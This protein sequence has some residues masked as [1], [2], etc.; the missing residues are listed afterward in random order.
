[1]MTKS[2]AAAVR[3]RPSRGLLVLLVLGLAGLFSS[4]LIYSGTVIGFLRF[5]VFRIDVAPAGFMGLFAETTL[6]V[7]TL[8]GV[9]LVAVSARRIRPIPF[10]ALGACAAVAYLCCALGFGFA[11]YFAV[12]VPAVYPLLGVA[13][14]VADGGLVLVW[15][16]VCARR[17]SMRLALVMVG[18]ASALSAGIDF[19]YGCLPLE[20]MLALLFVCSALAVV[21][22]L[23]VHEPQMAEGAFESESLSDAVSSAP[24]EGHPTLESRPALASLF[25][26]A[27]M[28]SLGLVAFAFVMAVMRTAFNEGQ[29]AYL[30]ALALS[31]A[32]IVVFALLK[33]GPF[34]LPGG[35]Q[36][37]FLPICALVVL[38]GGSITATLDAGAAVSDWLTYGL[39]S[40]AAVLTLATLCAV[41][42]AGEFSADLVFSVALC[43]FCGA[44]F[45][46]QQVGGA[47]PDE[48]ISVAVTVTTTLYAF[49]LVL[50][51]YV[52]RRSE[53]QGA[54]SEADGALP[55]EDRAVW[56]GGPADG[57][58]SEM[59]VALSPEV[60]GA[61]V[62]AEAA[63]L[64]Q[65]CAALAAAHGLTAREREILPYLAEGHNGSYIASVLF[66]SPNTARTHIHNIYRKL[67]VSSREDILRLTRSR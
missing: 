19:L 33:R 67:D 29:G 66:I 12:D 35:L 46:G 25:D 11:C 61:S 51:S 43:A 28:S 8:V 4:L 14:G 6:L 17:L 59:G 13:A 27:G 56:G 60:S 58:A 20:G 47:L 39:Y 52:R 42:H 36:Q 34:L 1:M 45:I 54:L 21:I 41:A 3:P 49:A 57:A 16:R 55:V 2:F 10:T 53:A 9:A 62:V 31:G 44:S 15:G 48:M 37:T 26:V 40:V 24:E 23:A 7:A 64:A 65:R 50:V 5:P 22:P 38:A 30:G 32:G 63:S 18:A